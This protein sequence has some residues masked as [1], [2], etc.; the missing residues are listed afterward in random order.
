MR[1]RELHEFILAQVERRLGPRSWAW[2]AREADVP[3][4]TLMTQK[5][6]PKFSV[7]VVASVA[8]ALDCELSDLVPSRGVA[9][10]H[11][12]QLLAELQALLLSDQAEQRRSG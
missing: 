9:K 8:D 7:D 6:R 2:L 1:G 11:A 10:P 5:G 3:R 4:S 12:T